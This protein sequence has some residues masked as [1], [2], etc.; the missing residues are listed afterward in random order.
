MKKPLLAL[1]LMLAAPSCMPP[2]RTTTAFSSR[3]GDNDRAKITQLLA[4]LP[5]EASEARTANSQNRPLLAA[6]TQGE[7][8]AVAL[9]DLNTHQ[10]LWSQP[11]A[12]SSTPDIV[13]DALVVEAGTA[14]VILDLATGNTRGRIEHVGLE[15][16]GAA[17]DGDTL[18]ISLAAGLAGGSGR[19]A[20][21]VVAV[22]AANGAERWS[23]DLGGLVGLSLIHI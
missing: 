10:A 9:Y 19:R 13:G 14:T 11:L 18:I 1:A 2:I 20:G 4:R 3:F 6:V 23:H 12:A 8:R 22:N 16:A 7:R 5:P 21:R 17:R 15:Y